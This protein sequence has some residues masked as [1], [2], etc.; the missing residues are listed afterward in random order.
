M[1]KRG[2]KPQP[3]AVAILNGNPGRRPLPEPDLVVTSGLPVTV[4]PEVEADPV[5]LAEFRRVVA[6]MPAGVYEALDTALLSVYAQAWS[7]FWRAQ[8]DIDQ[9]GTLIIEKIEKSFPDGSIVTTEKM[10]EN[11]AVKT[12]NMAATNLLKT[13]DRLG[14][15]PGVRAK[16]QLPERRHDRP[17]RPRKQP[18]ALADLM[19]DGAGDFG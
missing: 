1:G 8:A 18:T 3:L 7:I 15:V 9:H 13:A 6:A 5:A 19:P 17:G 10:K 4:P 11:P 14:L 2:R 12:W 16:L